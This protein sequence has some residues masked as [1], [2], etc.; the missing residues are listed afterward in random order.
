MKKLLIN[1][2]EFFPL[3]KSKLDL[4]KENFSLDNEL[5]SLKKSFVLLKEEC[6]I[7][8]IR[9]KDAEG[10]VDRLRN[11]KLNIALDLRDFPEA[12]K[13]ISKYLNDGSI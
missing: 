11:Q 1:I 7:R 2:K 6:E 5:I 10:E 3:L 12:K 8:K 13:A 9:Q 4:I